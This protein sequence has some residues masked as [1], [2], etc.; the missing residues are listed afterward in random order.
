L[1]KLGTYAVA[2]SPLQLVTALL[3]ISLIESG[4][5]QLPRN[6]C[7]PR[8]EYQG[9]QGQYIG[10]VKVR[11]PLVNNQSLILQF[12]QPGYHDFTVR[13]GLFCWEILSSI[14]LPLELLSLCL[15]AVVL[16]PKPPMTIVFAKV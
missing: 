4:L 14:T 12:S 3:V 6:G 9:Y 15:F 5:G 13:F 16:F 11:H 10:L 2:M 8:F 1:E 7:A